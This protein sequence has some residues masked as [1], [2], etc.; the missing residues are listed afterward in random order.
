MSEPHHET[1]RGEPLNDKHLW[2]LSKQFT[3]LYITLMN[4]GNQ[5]AGHV[6]TGSRKI[7]ILANSWQKDGNALQRGS[8]PEHCFVPALAMP[9][10]Q[11]P[12][13]VGA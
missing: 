9:D 3:W 5:R 11:V 6:S 1:L 8:L 2:W 13:L 12:G 7:A 4:S 10:Q